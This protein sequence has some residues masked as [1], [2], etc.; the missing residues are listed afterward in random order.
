MVNWSLYLGLLG[1]LLASFTQLCIAIHLLE[2]LKPLLKRTLALVRQV[3]EHLI[4]SSFIS[5]GKK[6]RDRERPND[7]L[8]L[9]V[10]IF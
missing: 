6:F 2:D 7:E 9:R 10:N 8:K 5:P 4:A 1:V 3:Y